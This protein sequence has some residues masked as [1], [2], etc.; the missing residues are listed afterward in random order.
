MEPQELSG[1]LIST[2]LLFSLV[3]DL[4]SYLSVHPLV[5]FWSIQTYFSNSRVEVAEIIKTVC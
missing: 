2:D 5:F 3:S 1:V 4:P